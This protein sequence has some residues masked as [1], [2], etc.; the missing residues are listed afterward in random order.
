VSV[1]LASKNRNFVI[2]PDDIALEKEIKDKTEACKT[3]TGWL[4][5]DTSANETKEDCPICLCELDQNV[6]LLSKCKGHCFHIP[7]ITQCFV[8][9]FVKCPI[10]GY[11]YGVRKGSQPKGTMS[12]TFHP[13]GTFPLTGYENCG[14]I[15]IVYKFPNGIQG[16]GHPNPGAEY[17]G[18]SRRCYLPDNEEGNEVLDLLKIAFQRKLTFAVGTSVTTGHQNC[19]VWNGIHHK[20][21]QS[22]GATNYGY[23][24]ETYFTRIKAELKDLG[25]Q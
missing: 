9:G 2:D 5:Q 17:T 4:L 14:T 20:T 24:D 21:S 8:E 1:T 25:V 15:V 7:C 10:C 13:V 22:G 16:Q 11:V 23:P 19:V 6:V 3:I 12:V 18:T